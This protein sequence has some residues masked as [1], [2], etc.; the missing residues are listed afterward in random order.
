MALSSNWTRSPASQV[1]NVGSIPARVIEDKTRFFRF[2][3]AES[4][5]IKTGRET[6]YGFIVKRLKTQ[7]SQG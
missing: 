6:E 7:P 3:S 4:S 1:G 5:L 2:L